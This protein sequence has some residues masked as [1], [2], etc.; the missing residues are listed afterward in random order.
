MQTKNASE[1]LSSDP[2]CKH[3]T[4]EMHVDIFV[5]VGDDIVATLFIYFIVNVFLYKCSSA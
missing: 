5:I 3:L 4:I 2:K 1:V